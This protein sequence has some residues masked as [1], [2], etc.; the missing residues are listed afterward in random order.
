ME[1]P[2]EASSDF[3]PWP[4]PNE[5]ETELALVTTD[6]SVEAC[7]LDK[8]GVD[9]EV[10]VS[11]LCR[12]SPLTVGVWLVLVELG[13]AATAALSPSFESGWRS[14]SIP[15]VEL[16]M[17]P[18]AFVV[19]RESSGDVAAARRVVPFGCE[20]SSWGLCEGSVSAWGVNSLSASRDPG[21]RGRPPT[22][23]SMVAID[24]WGQI[25]C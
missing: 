22:S 12:L 7:G 3:L 17:R 13:T 25:P 4:S 21:D 6:A 23:V 20:K 8:L 19:S 10:S 2:V 15:N 5:F 1:L 14:K 18:D 24:G 11:R 16:I 9:A